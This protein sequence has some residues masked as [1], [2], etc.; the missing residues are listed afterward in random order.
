MAIIYVEIFILWQ[1]TVYFLYSSLSKREGKEVQGNI[2]LGSS[3]FF[4]GYSLYKFFSMLYNYYSAE[5]IYRLLDRIFLVVGV[6]FFVFILNS[7]FFKQIFKNDRIRKIYLVAIFV[8]ISVFVSLYY[9]FSTLEN[10]ILLVVIMVPLLSI[11][12]YY[13][14]KWAISLYGQAKIY[15]GL[16]VLG[17]VLFIAGASLVRAIQF[18]TPIVNIITIFNIIEIIGLFFIAFGSM[19]LPKLSEIDWKNKLLKLYVIKTDGI[20]LFEHSFIELDVDRFLMSG[21][22]ASIVKFVKEMTK[23]DKILSTIKQGEKNIVVEHGKN[24]ILAL[25]VKEDQEIFHDKMKVFVREFES[26]FKDIIPIWKGDLEY[27]M[28]TKTLIEKI[29]K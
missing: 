1:I 20:C 11:L 19:G 9:L 21:G 17:C 2:A 6:I 18:L 3:F 13:S 22:I 14:S 27:F 10:L 29:F 23:S 16:F 28:P 25:I 26:F 15:L 5:Y 12:I 4:V 24:I 7:V 8:S